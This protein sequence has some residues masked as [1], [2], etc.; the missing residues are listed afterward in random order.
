[1]ITKTFALAKVQKIFHIH[2]FICVFA[3]D[4]RFLIQ[5]GTKKA[6]PFD[7]ALAR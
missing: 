5:K 2:K 4:L 1:M 6:Q 7:C 3:E